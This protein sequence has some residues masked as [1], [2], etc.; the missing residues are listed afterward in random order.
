[1]AIR[2]LSFFV[3]SLVLMA[4]NTLADTIYD[5]HSLDGGNSFF[6]GGDGF[7][8]SRNLL[9]D[10][11]N[12]LAP[13]EGEEWEIDSITFNML[14]VGDGVAPET[15]TDAG[16]VVTLLAGVVTQDSGADTAE[17]FANAAVL[18]SETF[19]LGDVT[20]G[21]NGA[22]IAIPMTVDFVN[23]INIGDGQDI[24]ITFEF[25]DS[26]S[27]SENGLLSIVYR[28]LDGTDNTP[29]VG[30]TSRINFRDEDQNGIINGTDNFAFFSDARLRFSIE[31]S[32]VKSGCPF[33]LGDTNEDGAVDLLD[34]T[35]FIDELANGGSSL[36]QADINGDGAVDLL[37]VTPFIAL[38]SGG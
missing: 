37:D 3:L 25:S 35:P 36:C 13:G 34:V 20:S 7:P 26:S 33:M 1:M 6:G 28:N 27:G 9:G 19:D 8:Q 32:A 21:D 14:V 29:G 38:L 22:A 10:D 30:E 31:A 15:F 2:L 16:V 18:G 17:Q 24:G 11:I 23:P 12:T 5:N 4:G